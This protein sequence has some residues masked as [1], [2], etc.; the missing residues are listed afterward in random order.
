MH[1]PPKA[2]PQSKTPKQTT[3]KQ[4]DIYMPLF[5]LF[6]FFSFFLFF[7]FQIH[8]WL[9]KLEFSLTITQSQYIFSMEYT[10][11]N[12]QDNLTEF[13]EYRDDPQLD[14]DSM[15]EDEGFDE[16]EVKKNAFVSVDETV[17]LQQEYTVVVSEKE[18]LQRR[19]DE[20]VMALHNVSLV[21]SKF[22][23]AHKFKTSAKKRA[24]VKRTANRQMWC[25]YCKSF[26][27]AR[28]FY[29]KNPRHAKKCVYREAESGGQ[30]SKGLLGL[31]EA[32][33]TQKS[34]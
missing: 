17:Q 12:P 21:H 16:E 7:L 5:P 1:L 34:G 15:D 19:N 31:P 11:E 2:K 3:P 13:G 27:I 26:D 8:I 4:H 25:P 20:L 24:Q 30:D 29:T 14:D 10:M 9:F 22:P 32:K 33:V 23:V 6:S 18:D 28:N